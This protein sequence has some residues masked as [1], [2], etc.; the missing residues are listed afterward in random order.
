MSRWLILVLQR[1]A[2]LAYAVRLYN[3]EQQD[4]GKHISVQ[5]CIPF[6]TK[7]QFE[8]TIAKVSRGHLTLEIAQ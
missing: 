8:P 3:Y 2:E 7:Q 6:E 1:G 4:E 5:A